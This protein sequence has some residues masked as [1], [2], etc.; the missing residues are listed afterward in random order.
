MFLLKD[1]N[2][3]EHSTD[4]S[5][6]SSRA[7]DNR[8][9]HRAAAPKTSYWNPPFLPAA[10]PF[11]PGFGPVSIQSSLIRLLEVDYRR[12]DISKLDFSVHYH[13]QPPPGLYV[14]Y[15]HGDLLL[16]VPHRIS[17]ILLEK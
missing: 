17:N 12:G 5:D 14:R 2:G 6:K 10:P 15:I 4:E 9:P 1:V 11:M 7:S 13:K 3:D 16:Y 8:D